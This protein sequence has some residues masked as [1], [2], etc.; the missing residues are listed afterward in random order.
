[1]KNFELTKNQILTWQQAYEWSK[2]EVPKYICFGMLP[3]KEKKFFAPFLK[4]GYVH[5]DTL[6]YTGVFRLTTK[7]IY[8]FEELKNKL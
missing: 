1:M 6:K 3:S 2:L 5:K 4:A 7:G 8:K